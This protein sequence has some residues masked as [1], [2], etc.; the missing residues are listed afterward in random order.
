[1]SKTT[2]KQ[3][4]NASYQYIVVPVTTEA[5]LETG[6]NRQ[7]QILA[8]NSNIQAVN[9]K[10]L[11]I[12]EIVFYTSGEIQIA[13]NLKVGMDS[14]GVVMVKTVGGAIKQISVADPSRKL[15]KIHLNV[16]G[17]IGT[18]GTNFRSF[19][20]QEKGV[21]EIAIELP[22]TVYAGKSVTIQL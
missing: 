6:G 22:Q 5:E 15:G 13:D 18:S 17:K 3:P 8:N 10:G 16:T 11:N 19:W 14:P 1:M 21:S 12:C 20:N 9:H 2:P 4:N 7:V